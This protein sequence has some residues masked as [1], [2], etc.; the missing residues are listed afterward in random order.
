M[1]ESLWSW[2]TGIPDKRNLLERKRVAAQPLGIRTQSIA[3]IVT[4][5]EAQLE[6]SG[7]RP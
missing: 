1:L 2:V 3:E 5:W 7:S 4:E 6:K